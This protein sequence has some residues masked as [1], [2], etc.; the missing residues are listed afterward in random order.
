MTSPRVSVKPAIYQ[1]A[2]E[3]NRLSIDEAAERFPHLPEWIDGLATPTLKQLEAFA[4]AMHAPIGFFFAEDPPDEPL[5][6]DDFRTIAGK[7][8]ARPSPDLLDTIYACQLRQA[9]YREF[10]EEEGQRPLPFVGSASID[11]DPVS[12]ATEIRRRLGFDVANRTKLS[13][14]LEALRRFIDQADDA[15]ILVMTSGIVGSATNRSLDPHEF[16]GFALSDPLAPLVFVNGADS[17]AAQMFTL[18]HELAHIWLGATGISDADIAH[19]P[20]QRAERWCDLVAAELLVPLV[21]LRAD[22]DRKAEVTGEAERLARRYKVSRLVMLRRMHDAGGLSRERMWAAY[23][24][25]LER[26]AALPKGKG[27]NFYL[28]TA[29]R[30]GKRFARA[31]LVSTW[32]GRSPYTEA[33]RLL[34][35][36]NAE[37]LQKLGTSVGMP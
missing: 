21:A 8:I 11:A 3:R 10:A 12:V 2:Y 34:S 9:W 35:L 13:T 32:E 19:P 4:H 36:R 7:S 15:G 18:A 17:K 33:F 27:G 22:Y 25:E 26:L 30:V 29:A 24:A 16:R 14:F 6:I 1:W 37:Q 5:P 23:E 20:A 31:M 28:S